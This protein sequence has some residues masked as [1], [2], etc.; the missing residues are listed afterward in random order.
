MPVRRDADHTLAT[1]LFTDIVGSTDLASEL[2]DRRWR[3]LLSG[4]HRLIRG[5]VKRFGGVEVDTAGDGFFIVFWDQADAVRCACAISDAVR[6]LGIE[7]R[8][9][10]NVGQAERIGKGFGGIAVH[11]GA[12]VMSKATAGEVLVSG[13]LRDLVPGSG[14]GFADRGVHE[15]RG[16]P[17][18]VRLYAVVEV[19]GVPRPS[20]LPAEEAMVRRGAI[21][22][23]PLDRVRA[24][25]APRGWKAAVAALAVLGALAGATL[26]LVSGGGGSPAPALA[27]PN[28]VVVV[29]PANGHVVR[30]VHVR[31]GA[32][33]ARLAAGPGG[34]WALDSGDQ[35]LVWLSE[36]GAPP[37]PFGV[38]DVGNDLAVGGGGV[39]IANVD[40]TVTE[41]DP[42]SYLVMGPP[43]PL[44]DLPVV[45]IGGGT[46]ATGIAVGAGALWVS[47]TR[48]LSLGLSRVGIKSQRARVVTSRAGGGPVTVASGDVWV[49][50]HLTQSGGGLPAAVTRIDPSSGKPT[51]IPLGIYGASGIALISAYGAI[52]YL[53]APGAGGTGT[54]WRLDPDGASVAGSVGV[55]S[56]PTGVAACG[57][58]IWVA[59]GHAG[60]IARINPSTVKVTL[61]V[62]L[63]R[64]VTGIAAAKHLWVAVQAS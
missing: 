42:R 13:V 18:G 55:G 46:S 6:E 32:Y 29:D 38:G 59:L 45:G 37:H 9:G 22:P 21:E 11:T 19:D 41:I 30:S 26:W 17:D 20:P 15:L 52:W 36:T 7:V 24:R 39:W 58:A 40:N 12:R 64:Y 63:G 2:G 53:T 62:R 49:G 54:L 27:S 48:S 57:G 61:R 1:V 4:H 33:P 60:A 31:L 56:D 25:A 51:R 28:T 10:L 8:A 3:V 47:Q 5:L 44:P 50:E 43:I 35:T 14:F 23:R 16:V 34:V